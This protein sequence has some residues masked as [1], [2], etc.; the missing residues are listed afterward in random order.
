MLGRKAV[1]NLACFVKCGGNEHEAVVLEGIAGNGIV[2]A[3][4]FDFGDY[5]ACK[6]ITRG[7]KHSQCRGIVLGLGNEVGSN[8]GSV[9]VFAGDDDLRR[10]SEHVDGTVECDES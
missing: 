2:A 6:I 4:A 7:N 1:G 9:A 8:P 3:A 5:V 10:A